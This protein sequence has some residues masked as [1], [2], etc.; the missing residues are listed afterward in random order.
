MAKQFTA[1]Q[2]LFAADLQSR[3][4]P[5]TDPAVQAI[6]ARMADGGSLGSRIQSLFAD[7]LAYVSGKLAVFYS[8]LIGGESTFD[9]ASKFVAA[10]SSQYYLAKDT[11]L[12]AAAGTFVENTLAND[13]PNI[14]SYSGGDISLAG[15]IEAAWSD[16]FD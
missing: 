8:G 16:S 6:L 12:G 1:V 14:V 11:S 3:G 13:I 9:L 4:V 2:D 7:N 10:N 5:L 15:Q